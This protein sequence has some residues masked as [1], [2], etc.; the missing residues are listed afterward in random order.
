M[1]EDLLSWKMSRQVDS[2]LNLQ[3]LK[4]S[5]RKNYDERKKMIL[6][7]ILPFHSILQEVRV[8]QKE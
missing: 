2:I 4:E 6:K 5:S 7:M 3:G 8:S 1:Q